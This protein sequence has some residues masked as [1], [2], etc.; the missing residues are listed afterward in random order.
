[1]TRM[2]ILL[3]ISQK[4]IIVGV[5]EM[6]VSNDLGASLVTYS[7]GS[8]LGITLYDPL[9]RVGGLLHAMLPNSSIDQSKAAQTPGAFIDTGVPL[10]FR[11]AYELA[12]EKAILDVHVI[13]GAELMNDS[14]LFNIGKR[15]Y[16]AL[17]EILDRNGVPVRARC[18][19]G[20]TSRTVFLKLATG[21]VTIKCPGEEDQCL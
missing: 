5:G 16:E 15:N 11:A 9:K 6:A 10:L 17:N 1:M 19:G 4:T 3:P 21:I 13:G 18:I 7:L 12:A 2:S 20:Q 8:C 14:R